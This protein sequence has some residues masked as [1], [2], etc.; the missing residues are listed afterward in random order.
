[1]KKALSLI[2]FFSPFVLFSQVSKYYYNSQRLDEGITSPEHKEWLGKVRFYSSES[3]SPANVISEKDGQ[4]HFNH[5]RAIEYSFYLEQSPRAYFEEWKK[6][7]PV[8]EYD[9]LRPRSVYGSGGPDKPKQGYF[10]F[11]L[12]VDG[13]NVAVWRRPILKYAFFHY[14]H[15]KDKMWE[16]TTYT[17]DNDKLDNFKYMSCEFCFKPLY[18]YFVDNPSEG[19]YK[20]DLKVYLGKPEAKTPNDRHPEVMAEG[21]FKITL[22][23]KVAK[24]LRTEGVKKKTEFTFS[25]YVIHR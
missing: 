17:S 3:S 14:T 9:T 20:V 18:N 22:D 13:Q 23:S 15:F 8:W 10:I 1:M 25:K 6:T 11:E 24:E 12:F 16:Y 19:T 21:G 5:L 7:D 4:Y 2:L